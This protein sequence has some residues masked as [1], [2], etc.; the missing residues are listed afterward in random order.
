M[1]R[2]RV[3]MVIRYVSIAIGLMQI[4]ALVTYISGKRTRPREPLVE[5]PDRK[6]KAKIRDLDQK[7][8]SSRLKNVIDIIENSTE[9]VHNEGLFDEDSY[10]EKVIEEE[11]RLPEVDDKM[12]IKPI[13]APKM[14]D[15]C[16][17][18]IDPVYLLILVMSSPRQHK[19]RAKIRQTW[20]K[21]V[22]LND[23]RIMVRFV[24]GMTMNL[25]TEMMLERE[26]V[27][28]DD[29]IQG[30][31]FE[32]GNATRTAK[33]VFG[34]SWAAHHCPSAHFI[35]KTNAD[36]IVNIDNLVSYL[37]SVDLVGKHGNF[38]AG[39]I[40][41]K[42]IQLG[43]IEQENYPTTRRIYVDY[44]DG[45]GYILS[46]AVARYLNT[47]FH[48]VSFIKQANLYIGVCLLNVG[49]QIENEP[50]F[51]PQKPSEENHCLARDAFIIHPVTHSELGYLWSV[52]QKLPDICRH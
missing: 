38:A 44:P 5:S 20:G 33:V 34:I 31:F 17:S 52:Y 3:S 30:E 41:I 2:N 36:V 49:V 14:S 22:R 21:E 1:R 19:L 28:F 37:T 16:F 10:A 9:Y 45:R 50:W 7:A 42:E 18:Q 35:M 11:E 25:T 51:A 39:K 26:S 43:A 46:G 40:Y 24:V 47:E 15:T 12:L 13:M 23:L 27:L 29:V 6:A 48:H 8:L 32:R 4:I